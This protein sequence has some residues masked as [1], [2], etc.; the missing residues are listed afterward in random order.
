LT[1][2]RGTSRAR[3]PRGAGERPDE[4]MDPRDNKG[5]PGITPDA[6]SARRRRR[7]AR[8]FKR[9]GTHD[10][11]VL[12]DGVGT[13]CPA[14]GAPLDQQWPARHGDRP[15]RR[16]SM[17]LWASDSKPWSS[18]GRH[19]RSAQHAYKPI[20]RRK[21]VHSW[22]ELIKTSH[23]T[24]GLSLKWLGAIRATLISVDR[25]SADGRQ[26]LGGGSERRLAGGPCPRGILW[27]LLAGR[28]KEYAHGRP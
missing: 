13:P 6:Q 7:Q 21:V 22:G 8:T 1:R 26:T 16:P 15:K 19:E 9:C 2:V 14:L 25:Y 3:S 24:S 17:C 18:C 11:A 23:M 5:R 12:A 28:W 10:R 4:G 27:R 20:R